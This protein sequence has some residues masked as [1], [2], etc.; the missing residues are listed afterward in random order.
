MIAAGN[1]SAVRDRCAPCSVTTG[2]HVR[3][4]SPGYLGRTVATECTG[5]AMPDDTVFA[6]DDPRDFAR[7][8][9]GV[10][11]TPA[12]IAHG[13]K[14]WSCGL[15]LPERYL[16]QPPRTAPPSAAVLAQTLA[17]CWPIRPSYDLCLRA[18]TPSST[19]TRR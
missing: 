18:S 19:P 1:Q 16:H 13:Y 12:A 10:K 14:D 15:P 5:P 7:E 3:A 11:P 9:L 17:G 8:I 2:D 4:L 6:R